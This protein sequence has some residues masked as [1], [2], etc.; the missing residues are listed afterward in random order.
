MTQLTKYEQ[1]LVAEHVARIQILTDAL[2]ESIKRFQELSCAMS[3]HIRS[4]RAFDK[5]ET[6]AERG[7]A[8]CVNAL[9]DAGYAQSSCQYANPEQCRHLGEKRVDRGMTFCDECGVELL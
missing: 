6:I 5:Y 4:D 9:G 8:I 2:E 7:E 3:N 1:S